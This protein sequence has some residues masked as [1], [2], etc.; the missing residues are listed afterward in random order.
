M[1]SYFPNTQNSC[2]QLSQIIKSKCR[3]KLVCVKKKETIKSPCSSSPNSSSSVR[4]IRAQCVKT[5]HILEN[6]YDV[7][8][9]L[10]KLDIKERSTSSHGVSSYVSLPLFDMP[11]SPCL[12]TTIG[13]W[14]YA[15]YLA[16]G[17]IHPCSS[18]TLPLMTEWLVV[19]LEDAGCGCLPLAGHVVSHSGPFNTTIRRTQIHQT[20][21]QLGA[22]GAPERAD[23]GLSRLI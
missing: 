23:W 4:Q 9:R 11:F 8:Q 20:L 18:C 5:I 10:R 21:V 16:C 15:C 2:L 1:F 14:R 3:N 19:E 22:R 17:H 7:L 6:K 12:S 13:P